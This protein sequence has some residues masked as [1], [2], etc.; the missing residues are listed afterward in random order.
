MSI[1]LELGVDDLHGKAAVTHFGLAHAKYLLLFP[2]LSDH[3]ER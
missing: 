2:R 1:E 3:F